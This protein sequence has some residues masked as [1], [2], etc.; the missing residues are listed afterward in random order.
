[1]HLSY[2]HS[3]RAIAIMVIVL[4]HAPNAHDWS[5]AGAAY[6]IFDQTVANATILFVFVSGFLFEHLGEKYQYPAYLWRKFKYIVLPYLFVSIPALAY[7][8]VHNPPFETYPF[9]ED[10]S[11]L[12]RVLWMYGVGGAHINAALWYIPTVTVLFLAAPIFIQFRRHPALYGLIPLLLL[13]SLFAHRP[14]TSAFFMGYAVENA[15]FFAPV[16]VLGMWTSHKREWLERWMPKLL[17]PTLLLY[18]AFAALQFHT[19][20]FTG[21]YGGEHLFSQESGLIDHTLIRMVLLCYL[22]LCACYLWSAPLERPLMFIGT[23][24][25]TIYFLHYYFVVAL[26]TVLDYAYPPGQLWYLLGIFPALMAASCLCAWIGRKLL[27]RYSRY[28][29]GS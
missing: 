6:R 20:P 23:V 29:I 13:F 28:F 24:S 22:V 16:Y 21:I 7:S 1:M 14:G 10:W 18:L 4:N 27:G 19:Q 11:V 5:E 26:R 12:R 15:A 17:L 2:V 8:A 25:F 3:F 9:L